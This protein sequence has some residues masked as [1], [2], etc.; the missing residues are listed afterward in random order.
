T[1]S[2]TTHLLTPSLHDALP[3]FA[4][5]LRELRIDRLHALDVRFLQHRER[6]TTAQELQRRN[7]RVELQDLTK[8]LLGNPKAT[9]RNPFKESLARKPTQRLTHMCA[10]HAHRVAH[11]LLAN[12]I[13]GLRIPF[14]PPVPQ[15]L[16]PWA[17]APPL[18]S[19]QPP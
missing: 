12:E 15:L 4:H 17:T 9:M 3:I 11:L 1:R 6:K 2:S 14:Q 19:P 16:S 18:P 5:S 8:R 7:D 13:A 10:T